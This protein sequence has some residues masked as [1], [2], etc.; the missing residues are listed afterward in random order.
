MFFPGESVS[1]RGKRICLQRESVSKGGGG[2]A[3]RGCCLP[4][5]PVLTSS[6]RYAAYWN[7]FFLKFIITDSPNKDHESDVPDPDVTTTTSS[8]DSQHL[9]ARNGNIYFQEMY[10][11]EKSKKVHI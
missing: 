11:I 7:A 9:R 4:Y 8:G 2:S 6:G 1:R 5:P 3:S 10:R